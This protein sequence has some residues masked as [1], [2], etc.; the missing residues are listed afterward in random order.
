MNETNN[1]VDDVSVVLAVSSA[2]ATQQAEELAQLVTSLIE[3]GV[4]PEDLEA[5]VN[6]G[7]LR[8]EALPTGSS[9]DYIRRCQ[10]A[11]EYI[12]QSMMNSVGIPRELLTADPGAASVSEAAA[13]ANAA[14][15]DRLMRNRLVSQTTV[16]REAGFVFADEAAA[17]AREPSVH[18]G[19]AE[20]DA[21]QHAMFVERQE[22]DLTAR[23]WEAMRTAC[24][25]YAHYFGRPVSMRDYH[26]FMQI[27]RELSR[28]TRVEE[29]RDAHLDEV[30]TYAR[31]YAAAQNPTLEYDETP[32]VAVTVNEQRDTVSWS[33]EYPGRTPPELH[34]ALEALFRS[35][36]VSVNTHEIHQEVQGRVRDIFLDYIRRY[37]PSLALERV[38]YYFTV[39]RDM[40]ELSMEEVRAWT[41]SGVS[42]VADD[43]LVFAN[44]AGTTP[45]P[46]YAGFGTKAAWSS[47]EIEHRQLNPNQRSDQVESLLLRLNDICRIHHFT[48]SQCK[49]TLNGAAPVVNNCR[50]FV[51]K[52]L[53]ADDD[54][55]RLRLIVRLFQRINDRGTSEWGYQVTH[56]DLAVGVRPARPYVSPEV[57]SRENQ[58]ARRDDA[59]RR[60]L[61]R[62][63][64]RNRGRLPSPPVVAPPPRPFSIK[65][66]D[67]EPPE[68]RPLDL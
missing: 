66:E 36:N 38:S 3:V 26:H 57:R 4:T 40:N 42:P 7:E 21:Q 28:Y 6:T 34:E 19:D 11:Q 22:D 1:E 27:G 52:V 59:R 18:F 48:L 53:M 49:Y 20:H 17:V 43:G 30:V 44:T 50:T 55:L 56:Q 41:G 62:D 8:I 25:S 47:D 54:T 58:Q 13:F 61:E 67:E 14:Q 51:F 46:L 15:F 2:A 23:I 5:A 65:P 33:A 9:D 37:R 12:T 45:P 60:A 10:A 64:D 31:A 32:R 39:R 68:G 63:P 16:L 29:S 35:Y 24:A